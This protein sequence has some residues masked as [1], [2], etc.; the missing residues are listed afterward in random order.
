MNQYVPSEQ[1]SKQSKLSQILVRS[2]ESWERSRCFI[3]RV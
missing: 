3:L 1:T 2:W